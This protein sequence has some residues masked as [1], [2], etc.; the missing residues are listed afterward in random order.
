M[1]DGECISDDEFLDEVSALLQKLE[2]SCMES[3]EWSPQAS[4]ALDHTASTFLGLKK[5]C[6]EA[7]LCWGE[8]DQGRTQEL[9]KDQNYLFEWEWA[10]HDA[11]GA[12]SACGSSTVS[13]IRP[14]HPSIQWSPSSCTK[15]DVIEV[16]ITDVVMHTQMELN[17]IEST[18]SSKMEAMEQR[19]ERMF[20]SQDQRIELLNQKL[21]DASETISVL[22][23]TLQQAGQEISR[24]QQSKG[25]LKKHLD[26][27][28]R[29]QEAH[30]HGICADL[31]KEKRDLA[32]QFA[33]EKGKYL[34]L[35]E[36]LTRQPEKV[37]SSSPTKDHNCNKR[38]SSLGYRSQNHLENNELDAIPPS[39]NN[40]ATEPEQ[41]EPQSKPSSVPELPPFRR[42]YLRKP[43]RIS[44]LKQ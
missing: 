12:E 42:Y 32:Q 22:E 8:D 44:Y 17:R 13:S 34:S 15:E 43:S 35:K 14:S 38:A 33:Q 41:A 28:L 9:C 39:P 25:E 7:G 6:E 36:H 24:I 18:F 29:E 30:W 1:D 16:E 23:S 37:T 11:D 10:E 21:S 4:S 31:V 5:V 20:K 19:Y 3:I 2:L 40:N 26:R 27:A